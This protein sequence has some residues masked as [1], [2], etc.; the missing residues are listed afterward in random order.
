[1]SS[2]ISNVRSSHRAQLVVTA[3]VSGAVAA[4]AVI[5]YQNLR[6]IKKVEDLKESIPDIGQ[7]HA[8]TRVSLGFFFLVREVYLRQRLIQIQ[9]NEF[10]AA[11]ADS[12][13]LSKEDER[14]IVL[15]NRARLGDYDE[16]NT[17]IHALKS[18]PRLPAHKV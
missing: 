10:G 2:W 5:A 9:L 14:G 1:M 11:A 16:G 4:S 7:E 8:A 6:R 15:A 12:N 13:A 3:A 17:Y 18:V